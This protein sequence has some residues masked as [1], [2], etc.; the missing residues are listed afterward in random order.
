[1][2]EY[3]K[4]ALKMFKDEKLKGITIVNADTK[5]IMVFID[6]DGTIINNE[7]VL[8]ILNYYNTENKKNII[9]KDGK[10]YWKEV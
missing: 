5:E 8:V 7:E 3:N 1:M 9:E 4:K 6:E 10:F 2:E